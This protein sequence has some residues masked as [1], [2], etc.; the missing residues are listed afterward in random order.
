MHIPGKETVIAVAAGILFGASPASSVVAAEAKS[1]DQHRGGSPI[2]ITVLNVDNANAD[3]WLEIDRAGN[4]QSLSRG[5]AGSDHEGD[6][7][8]ADEPEPAAPPDSSAPGP[9]PS[10]PDPQPAAQGA[11]PSAQRPQ[12][13]AQSPQPPAQSPQPSAQDPRVDGTGDV[14]PTARG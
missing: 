4:V 2:G 3:S 14:L 13:S 6:D 10:A 7:G 12:P 1:G 8:A 9:Q 5:D 11:P